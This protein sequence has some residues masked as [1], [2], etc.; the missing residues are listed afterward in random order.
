MLCFSKASVIFKLP[1][2]FETLM[3]FCKVGSRA[4]GVTINCRKFMFYFEHLYF[5]DFEKL[6]PMTEVIYFPRKYIVIFHGYA[7]IDT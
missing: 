4:A 2:S 5:V 1:E 6:S 7:H 3:G